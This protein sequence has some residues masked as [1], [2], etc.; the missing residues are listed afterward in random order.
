MVSDSHVA[1]VLDA[2]L[3][4]LQRFAEDPVPP[5]YRIQSVVRI[6]KRTG[7]PISEDKEIIEGTDVEGAAWLTMHDGTE[8]LLTLTTR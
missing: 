5:Q 6:G 1:Q 2:F 4:V 3:S 8:L 7:R